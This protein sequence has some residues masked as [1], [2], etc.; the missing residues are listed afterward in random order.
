MISHVKFVTIPT[1]DQDRAVKFWTERAGFRVLTDQPFDDKQR[2]IE[3][4]VGSSDTRLVL[5]DMGNGLQPGV[6]FNGAL[7]CDNVEK[8]YQE[9]VEKGVEFVA[10]P[11]RQPWGMF[12]IFKDLDGNTFMISTP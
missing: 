3:L 11:T 2:W 8:T 12:A 9:L 6:Q 7:A 5:F 10:P 1:R 4:R